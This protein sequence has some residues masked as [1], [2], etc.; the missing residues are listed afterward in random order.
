MNGKTQADPNYPDP[1]SLLGGLSTASFLRDYWQDKPLL[2]R[3]AWPGFVPPVTA[4]E[5]AGLACESEVESR[6]I[7]ERDGA[8][9]WE[10]RHGPFPEVVFAQLPRSHWSLLVQRVERHVPAAADLLRHFLFIPAW[11]IDDLMISFASAHGS[12]GA[13]I[14]QYDVF[15][16]QGLGRREWQIN[17]HDYS[18]TDFAADLD[19]TLLPDF[20]PTERWI[21]EPGDMLYLPPGIA[22]HGIA[23]EDCMT[24]S[25]GFRAPSRLDLLSA[26]ADD[27]L[28]DGL[29][30]RYRDPGLAPQDH[31]HE[32][33]EDARAALR[34]L[35][36]EALA[37]DAGLDRWLG[38]QLTRVDTEPLPVP[39]DPPWEITV[40]GRACL[41]R[42]VLFRS[43]D[44]RFLF[45]S[46]TD[47]A[48]L[49]ANGE[50]YP[51]ADSET[52][53]WL[54]EHDKL[55]VSDIDELPAATV[56]LLCTL[57]NRGL[58]ELE[59]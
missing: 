55:D 10:V 43:L 7:L 20:K 18:E 28:I 16:L 49:Y 59:E 8:Y 34:G 21:L 39:R 25:I 54:A 38:Q 19:L 26:Y 22:H 12:V 32:L 24:L 36:R 37:D 15:L 58:L 50:A 9:P 2:V 5:L 51:M 48:M 56:E 35:L 33:T 11:R 14:D 29:D 27:C 1:P 6:L 42:G 47:G 4:D 30:R 45:H 40:F 53:S 23:L 52:A 41:E 57:F 44:A 31:S 13:H 3:G 46:T 17:D